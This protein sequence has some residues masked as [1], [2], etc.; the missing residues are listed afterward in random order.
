MTSNLI[1]DDVSA[2]LG[3]FFFGGSGPSHTDLTRAFTAS[4]YAADAVY[5]AETKTPNKQ[6]RVLQACS[7]ARRRPDRARELIEQLLSLLRVRGDL[8]PSADDDAHS[9]AL[10]LALGRIGWY[11]TDD[12]AL[13]PFSGVDFGTG[14]RRALDEQLERLRRATD[15]PALLIGTA[16]DLLEAIA[17]FVLEE[18]EI[19]IPKNADFNWLWYHARD[20]LGIRPE[21]V[22]PNVPGYKQIRQIHQS[23]WTIAEQVNQLRGLQGTGHGRTLPTGVTSDLALL[24]VREAGSV[25]EYMLAVHDRMLGRH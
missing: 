18:L 6:Q 10:R 13:R 21:N 25:A 5:D 14:G 16:K 22:D 15:D 20:R 4:G 2:A 24:V 11:L 7:A 12:G 17:K 8:H 3:R 9:K 1:S 19:E 23:T